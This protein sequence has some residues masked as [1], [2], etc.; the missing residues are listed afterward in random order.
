[1]SLVSVRWV[2]TALEALA[3]SPARTASWIARC[4]S[5]TSARL[6][7]LVVESRRAAGMETTAATLSWA[8]YL[9]ARHPETERRLHAETDAVLAGLRPPMSIC[10]SWTSPAA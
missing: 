10:R 4:T 9:L 1:M 5:R 7:V 3:S 6:R 2:S 8:L